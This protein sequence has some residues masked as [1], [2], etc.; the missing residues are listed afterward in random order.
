MLVILLKIAG[1]VLVLLSLIALVRTFANRAKTN[2]R[3]EPSV[4]LPN[5]A[6]QQKYA[7]DLSHMIQI[8]TV[9]RRGDSDLTRFYRFHKL[10]EGLFPLIHQHLTKHNFDGAL[11]YRWQGKNSEQDAILLMSHIDV[12]EALGEWKHPPF[13]GVIEDGCIWGRGAVDTKGNVCAFFEAV[14]ELLNEGFTPP[15]DVYLACSNTEEISGDGAKKTAQYL[16]EQQIQLALV[17]DEGNGI[18]E[19]PMPGTHGLYAMFGIAEK[20]YADITFTARSQG[21]HSCLPTKNSPLARLGAFMAYIDRH[22]PFKSTITPPIKALLCTLAADLPFAK[23]LLLSN[24]WLFAPLVKYYLPKWS[25]RIA[26]MTKTTCN[27][28]MAQGSPAPNVLPP[29]ACVTANL[30]LL[31]QQS[32]TS[33]LKRLQSIGRRFDITATLSQGYDCSEQTDPSG[34]VFQWVSHCCKKVFPE[35]QVVPF[36]IPGGTDARFY[37]GLSNNVIRFAPL[38][39]TPQ[40]LQSAH[41]VNENLSISALARGVSFYRTLILSL[42]SKDQSFSK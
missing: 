32:A 16:K 40:Q 23:S 41:G 5:K 13:S 18:I 11:L 12:V 2:P 30:R 15:C 29:S 1:G 19:E 7:Q 28:T 37:T 27:F 33:C 38:I 39:F 42:P 26:A 35:S 34:A 24:L 10:L 25:P 31:P 8:E 9:S 21:G 22:P 4:F 36:L 14:E 20:G 17:I 6:Q 3:A